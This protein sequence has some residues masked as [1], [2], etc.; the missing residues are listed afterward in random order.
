MSAIVFDNGLKNITNIGRSF[1]KKEK[2]SGSGI[3]VIT[4]DGRPETEDGSEKR[5]ACFGFAQHKGR[6]A[7]G[8]KEMLCRAKSRLRLRQKKRA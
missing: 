5:R 3:F 6:R 2:R 7:Q 8:K 4:E 1:K